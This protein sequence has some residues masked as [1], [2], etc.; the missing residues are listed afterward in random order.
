L[1]VSDNF[2]YDEF[3]LIKGD[4]HGRSNWSGRNGKNQEEPRKEEETVA[5]LN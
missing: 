2:M 4:T 1:D 5:L 3:L